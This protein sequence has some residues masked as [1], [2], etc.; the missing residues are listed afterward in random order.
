MWLLRRGG[1]DVDVYTIPREIVVS[2]QRRRDG[3]QCTTT[4]TWTF[5]SDGFAL[6]LLPHAMIYRRPGRCGLRWGW[7]LFEVWTQFLAGVD[8]IQ[9]R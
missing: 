3:A 4:V 8:Q 6:E 9:R 7:L 5:D 1:F 2:I